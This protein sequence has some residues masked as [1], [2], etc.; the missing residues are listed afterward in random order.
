MHSSGWPPITRYWVGFPSCSSDVPNQLN[1][2]SERFTSSSPWTLS[3][4]N[5]LE[6][7]LNEKRGPE[8]DEYTTALRNELQ[9]GGSVLLSRISGGTGRDQ[10]RAVSY[11]SQPMRRRH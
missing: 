1:D 8:A 9:I 10:E 6:L 4:S 5:A 3:L 2:T 11:S 7:L